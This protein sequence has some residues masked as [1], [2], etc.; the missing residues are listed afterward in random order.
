MRKSKI[1]KKISLPINIAQTF[2]E[3]LQK[4]S[5]FSYILTVHSLHYP[6]LT[7]ELNA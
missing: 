1:F 5:G 3:P 7:V 2:L 6:K 4:P